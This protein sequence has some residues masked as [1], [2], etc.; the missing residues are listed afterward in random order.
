[1]TTNETSALSR[2]SAFIVWTLIAR[3]VGVAAGIALAL[4][5]A[6]AIVSLM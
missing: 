6:A 2:E 1:M 4:I 3:S 5:V